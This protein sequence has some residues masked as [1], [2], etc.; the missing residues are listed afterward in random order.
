MTDIRGNSGI[1]TQITTVKLS[2]DN[3]KE[4]VDLMIE[5]A[6]FMASQPGFVSINLHRSKDGSHV[7]T[8]SSGRTQT[9]SQRPIIRR[10]SAK[11]GHALG[12][13]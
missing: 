4:V 5:R 12:N 1:V 8:T 7:S 3:Q 6:R 2:P 10:S 13:L 9:S 11:N